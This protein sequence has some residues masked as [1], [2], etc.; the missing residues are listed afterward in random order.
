MK[1]VK[2]ALNVD[3][4]KMKLFF[5]DLSTFLQH[6][7]WGGGG[8]GEQRLKH[9]SMLWSCSGEEGG[10]IGWLLDLAPQTDQHSEC[11]MRVKWDNQSDVGHRHVP[12]PPLCCFHRLFISFET[13]SPPPAFT[14]WTKLSDWRICRSSSLS[15]ETV[16]SLNCLLL[17]VIFTRW[18]FCCY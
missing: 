16:W 13:A 15:P 3:R 17:N 11:L 10:E 1:G 5:V 8:D 7:A 12:F 14:A 4:K 2:P 6:S 18:S 9:V